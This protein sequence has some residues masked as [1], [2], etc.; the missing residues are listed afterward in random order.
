[1]AHYRDTYRN[2]RFLFLDVRV[3]VIIFASLLHVRFWTIGLDLLVIG[4]AVY[5]ERIGLG[6]MGTMRAVRHWA[7]GNY[8][9][10]L[11][12]GKIRRSVDYERTSL[13]WEVRPD[14]TPVELEPIT[15]Q[16]RRGA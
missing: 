9:P 12:R 14:A 15:E 2:A 1:M 4:L 16:P 8:R 6:F 3:G 13:A 5:V 10:A 7:A 11:P